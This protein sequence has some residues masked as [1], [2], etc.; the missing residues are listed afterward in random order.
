MYIDTIDYS[1]PEQS[2]TDAPKKTRW[3][4]MSCPNWSESKRL[5]TAQFHLNDNLEKTKLSGEKT[6]QLS[7]VDG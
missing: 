5:K 4:K 7:V 6:D 1:E 3:I 2:A